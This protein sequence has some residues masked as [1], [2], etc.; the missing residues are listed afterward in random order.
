MRIL[1]YCENLGGFMYDWHKY[2]MIDELRHHGHDVYYFNPIEHLG[3]KGTASEYS[4]VLLDHI[5]SAKTNYNL[6]FS[7][8]TDR[9]ILSSAV[10]HIRQLGIPSVNLSTDDLFIPFQVK[11]IS[12]EYDL[13]WTT[14]RE[15][16]HIL[17]SYGANVLVQPWGA[18]PYI[19]KPIEI[20]ENNS[21]CFIGTPYGAR[22]KHLRSLVDSGI[23]V[24]LLGKI[25]ST[26]NVKQ[27]NDRMIHRTLKNI[28]SNIKLSLE[29]L[30]FK[31]GRVS[32][33]GAMVRL[34][35]EILMKEDY[36]YLKKII[37]QNGPSFEDFSKVI[38]SNALSLGSIE[39]AS[40]YKLLKPLLFI[41]LREFEV[42]MSGGIHLVNKSSELME[43]FND[44]EEML[45]YESEYELIDK[46]KYYLRENNSSIRKKIRFNARK[47]A[48]NEHTWMHRFTKLFEILN[49]KEK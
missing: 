25:M 21:I 16:A 33:R 14:V 48:V 11:N 41:R 19:Y 12:K 30:K 22:N 42:P 5:K 6:F 32:L 47:R 1:H 39:L 24:R 9:T 34:I 20:A 10:A 49:L 31:S 36:N 27:S 17:N 7:T 35:S 8:A 29:L 46:A 26:E 23:N 28:T 38:C 4:E 15:N 37:F 44:N 43:Y 40:T 13:A 2:H 45:F 3:K 18:N